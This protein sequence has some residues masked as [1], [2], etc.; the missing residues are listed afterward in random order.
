MMD[1]AIT[2]YPALVVVGLCMTTSLCA[3]LD[4]VRAHLRKRRRG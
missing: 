3:L 4:D 2:L 1:P